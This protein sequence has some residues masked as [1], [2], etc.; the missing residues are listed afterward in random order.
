VAFLLVEGMGTLDD[1]SFFL[2]SLYQ[3]FF[4]RRLGW[5]ALL[6]CR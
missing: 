3:R 2:D 4:H 6:I 5:F 1:K